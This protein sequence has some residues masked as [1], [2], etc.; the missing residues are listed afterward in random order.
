MGS[1][2]AALLGLDAASLARFEQTAD[3]SVPEDARVAGEMRKLG[4]NAQ[5]R[6]RA[7]DQFLR[8][9]AF[10]HEYPTVKAAATTA[11]AVIVIEKKMAETQ[12]RR[13]YPPKR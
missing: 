6:A 4:A 8:Q 13:W 12:L 10:P 9:T 2:P 3:L 5:A 1:T 11:A 7:A